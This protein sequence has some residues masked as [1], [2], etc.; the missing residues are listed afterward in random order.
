MN[1]KQLQKDAM[2]VL[3]ETSRTFYIPITFLD[4]D[5]KHAVGAAYLCMRALDEI[6]DN[7][8]VDNNTKH[9]MLLAVA[10]LFQ[11]PFD[12][13]AYQ[14]ILADE[15][16]NMPEVTLRMKDWIEFCP[17]GARDIMFRACTEMAQGMGKWCKK[18]FVVETRD[19]LDEY[20]YIVAGLVGRMLS[21]MWE[22]KTGLVTDHDLGIGYGRGLQA[23]NILRNQEEDMEERGV[24]FVPNGWTRDD[25]FAYAD[26]QLAH[27]DKYMEAIK[28]QK[29]IYMFAK[30]PHALAHKSLKAMKEGREK[31]SRAEVEETVREVEQETGLND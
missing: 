8:N 4:R 12:D 16:D 5:L 30:L 2:R 27:G 7:E 25:L 19:D 22:W 6:E 26:E 13:A 24:S 10:P 11:Y 18:N 28:S 15:K 1:E 29:R 21:E 31:I 20:T 9:D 14:A 23:V 17:E 3:K